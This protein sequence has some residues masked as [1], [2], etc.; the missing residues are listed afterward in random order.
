MIA[1]HS[2]DHVALQLPYWLAVT[3]WRGSEPLS[4]SFI[5]SCPLTRVRLVLLRLE[6]RRVWSEEFKCEE[7]KYKQ[8]R[9]KEFGK[10]R[11][12][13]TVD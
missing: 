1:V 10:W 13:E 3:F 4:S 6:I 8:F 7:L 2:C 5:N 11:W 12:E 9:C